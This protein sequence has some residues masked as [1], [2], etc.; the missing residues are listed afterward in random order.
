MN[1]MYNIFVFGTMQRG[2][3][4]HFYLK[5]AK[6]IGIALTVDEYVLLIT[7]YKEPVLTRVGKNFLKHEDSKHRIIGEVYQIDKTRLNNLDVVKQHPMR[8]SR[9][10][11]TVSIINS[12]GDKFK[13][14]VWI[15]FNHHE[16]GEPL[17]EGNYRAWSYEQEQWYQEY[18]N[19]GENV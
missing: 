4:N 13:S 6:F 16:D 12:N 10:L 17:P 7:H 18:R 14:D 5:D 8:S 3:S 11:K 19:K 1:E 15:Y 9:S 2:F